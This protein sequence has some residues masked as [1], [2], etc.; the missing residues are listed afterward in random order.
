MSSLYDNKVFIYLFICIARRGLDSYVIY[1]HLLYNMDIINLI[2]NYNYFLFTYLIFNVYIL[3]YVDTIVIGRL[4]SLNA[5]LPDHG[6]GMQV[7]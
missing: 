7:I 5:F 4:S 2:K 6:D 3:T 1:Q